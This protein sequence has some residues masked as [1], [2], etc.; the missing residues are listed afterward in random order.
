MT[1]QIGDQV[2]VRWGYGYGSVVISVM[3]RGEYQ[4][5][6]FGKLD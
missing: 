6:N 4:R 3:I 2:P 5:L 1:Y